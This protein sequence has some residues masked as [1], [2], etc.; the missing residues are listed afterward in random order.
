MR[1]VS[2]FLLPLFWYLPSVVE[3]NLPL[4]RGLCDCER[5]THGAHWKRRKVK[6]KNSIGVENI[7]TPFPREIFPR[8]PSYFNRMIPLL[9]CLSFPYSFHEIRLSVKS[10]DP[11][12][13]HG[14]IN[15][16]IILII[17]LRV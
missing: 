4:L 12:L 8:V 15:L 17:V 10:E 6:R 9:L 3:S 14:I 11:I 1:Y 16:F 7:D 13:N 2:P 5:T